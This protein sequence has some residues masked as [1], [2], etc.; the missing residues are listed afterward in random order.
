MAPSFLAPCAPLL[1]AAA[2]SAAPALPQ[3]PQPAE[4]QQGA[5]AAPPARQG[6]APPSD[7]A[8]RLGSPPGL[9]AGLEEEAMWPAASAEGWKQPCLV[10]WQRT[11]DDAVRVARAEHRPILVAVNMDGEIASE[12]FAGVSYRQPETAALLSRYACVVASVYR[13]T[14]R[15]Y[16]EDGRRVEC[17]RFETVTCGEHVEAE[18][19]LYE[20]YFDGKRIAPRH[21][22]LDLDGKETYDV[23]YS[24]DTATVFTAYRKGVEGWPEPLEGPEPTLPNL[25][26]SADVEDRESLERG[27]ADGDVETKRVILTSLLEEQAVD[28]VEVLRAAIFGL[29][30]GLAS[31]ARAALAKCETEGALD[32]MA[33]VLKSPLEASERQLLLEA[34]ARLAQGS[35]RARTLGALHSGLSLGSHH[36]G[37]EAAARLASEYEASAGR[38]VDAPARAAAAEARPDDPGALLELA[39]ALR[40]QAQG[41]EERRFADLLFEDARSAARSAERLGAKGPR[42]DAVMAVASAELGDPPTARARAVAAVEG[43]LLQAGETLA[44][45]GAGAATLDGASK[46]RVLRLFAEARQ[47]SIREAYRAGESWAPEWLSDVNA[48]YSVLAAG[49]LADATPLV[50]YHD[51]LRWIGATTRADAVL[52]EALQRFPD[53]PVLHERLRGRLL[54]E[55]GPEGLERGYAERLARGEAAGADATQISWFAGYASLVAAEHWRRRG[56]FAAAAAA[57]GRAIAHYERNIELFP[58]GRDTAL[59]FVALSEA[60]RARDALERGELDAA[61]GAMIAA[62]QL[63]PDSAASPDGLNITPVATAKMLKAKLLETGDG[64]RGARVQAALDALDPRLLEPPPSEQPDTGRRGQRGPARGQR[65]EADPRTGR[66]GAGAGHG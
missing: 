39:E 42:L 48:A 14:P 49:P 52:D 20:K 3:E 26:R 41:A 31:L 22:V 2:L 35:P 19:E 37:T 45:D 55:G 32:L 13:H 66:G 64:E 6:G 61:T 56:E 43:G 5:P 63:R 29:D 33:E 27:F 12:H 10:R 44:T 8:V 60:G 59:H 38:L 16:D 24:W 18:R 46:A 62:L 51:F 65:G 53:S 36:I 30:L 23:Y 11:F 25:V 57:Y 21:I 17:P 4:P 58:D 47:R 7:D 1:L 34:V 50:D 28:Q 15:D 40:A 9:P 54:W